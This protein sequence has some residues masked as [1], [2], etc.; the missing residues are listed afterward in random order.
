MQPIVQRNREA[1]R[2]MGVRDPNKVFARLKAMAPGQKCTFPD[3]TEVDYARAVEPACST[4]RGMSKN[5]G[6]SS[7][8]VARCSR[9]S[10]P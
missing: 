4:S 3:G 5:A 9:V 8:A 7:A 6:R 1:L 2:E 10:Q